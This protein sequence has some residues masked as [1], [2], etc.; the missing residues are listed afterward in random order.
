LLGILEDIFGVSITDKLDSID[1]AWDG[2]EATMATLPPRSVEVLRLRYV[3]KLTLKDAGKKLG[4]VTGCRA[5][6]IEQNALRQLRHPT[7]MYI[8]KSSIAGYWRLYA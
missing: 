4:N 8:I 5:R 1:I 3:E 2:L 6:Q 7:R